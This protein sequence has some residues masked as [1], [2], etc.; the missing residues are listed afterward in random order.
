VSVR[1]GSF[2]YRLHVSSCSRG[3]TTSL[4][5]LRVDDDGE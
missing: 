5:L 3:R 1:I 4:I 2:Q